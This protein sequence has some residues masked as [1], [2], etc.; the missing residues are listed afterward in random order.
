M[1]MV[2]IKK[3][4]CYVT[5]ILIIGLLLSGLV[6]TAGR[7]DW[8]ELWIFLAMYLTFFVS[9]AFYLKFKK[10]DLMKERLSAFRKGKKWDRVLISI[11]WI[12]LI[13]FLF[14]A[15]LDAGRYQNFITPT[16]L[17]IISL[18]I[19]V[20]AYA[21][22]FW[23]GVANEYLSSFVRIQKD[24]DHQVI[25][26]G[27]YRFVRHPMYSGFI[28]SYPFVALFLNSLWALIPAAIIIILFI[29]RTYL[30]DIHQVLVVM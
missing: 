28:I 2:E 24:R 8:I 29:V 9:W 25:K 3:T 14:T 6:L 17:K 7:L 30:E 16:L 13:A 22:Q 5:I 20:G 12:L 11:Y 26:K 19:L 4:L 15:A 1:K 18:L 27:P 23:S 21:F 10:P